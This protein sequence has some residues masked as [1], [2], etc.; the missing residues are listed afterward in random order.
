MYPHMSLP[1]SL[2]H[3]H[4][5]LLFGA[6]HGSLGLKWSGNAWSMDK[7]M[8]RA[9][10]PKDTSAEFLILTGEQ[11]WTLHLCSV[12]GQNSLH[13]WKRHILLSR[14]FKEHLAS[15]VAQM[16]K[17]LPA[18]PET[19]VWSLGGEDP[20]EEGMATHSGILAWRIPWTE[21]FGGLQSMGS[22]RAGHN[23]ETNTWVK[24]TQEQG[25]GILRQETQF[26]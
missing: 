25:I 16:V 19:P 2:H 11:F 5:F 1:A 7:Q 21:E 24:H 22:Q 18:M 4:L 6:C 20:L 14:L 15:L 17:I 10:P 23:W 8:T 13:M 12:V 26:C 3:I 9:M